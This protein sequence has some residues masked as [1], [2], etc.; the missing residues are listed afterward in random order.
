MARSTTTSKPSKHATRAKA[1]FKAK[2]KSQ[3]SAS[4]AKPASK[5]TQYDERTVA[6]ATAARKLATPKTLQGPVPK[7]VA[8]IM[9]DVG[10][11]REAIKAAGLSQKEV[12]EL[13]SGKG[14][15]EAKAKL[16]T[17]AEKVNGA[18]QWTRGRSLAAT[19]VAWIDAK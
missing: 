3:G 13:A 6:I 17:I 1:G 12:K 2:I 9:R 19:L 16:R 10:D 4:K 8:D 18:P 5:R 15:K 7:Q 11:P 14:S